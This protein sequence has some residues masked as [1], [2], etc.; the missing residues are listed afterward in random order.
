[1]GSGYAV[2]GGLAVF[3]AFR[4]PHLRGSSAA[5]APFTAASRACYHRWTWSLCLLCLCSLAVPTHTDCR[6]GA[7]LHSGHDGH[8]HS[9]HLPLARLPLHG[10]TEER[11][12]GRRCTLQAAGR[13][14]PLPRR[15]GHKLLYL[16]LAA[17]HPIRLPTMPFLYWMCLR[18]LSFRWQAFGIASALWV[19][20]C[21]FVRARSVAQH[22]PMPG[23]LPLSPAGLKIACTHGLLR[24]FAVAR[25]PTLPRTREHSWPHGTLPSRYVPFKALPARALRF[26]SFL[27]GHTLSEQRLV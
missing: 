8:E 12:G 5:C 4:L 26:P 7:C 21:S 6:G 15:L 23:A 18:S 2:D 9:S 22:L 25:A 11:H 17:A 13:A 19:G 16:I 27:F 3:A 14:A 20:R 10:T 24:A 1:V